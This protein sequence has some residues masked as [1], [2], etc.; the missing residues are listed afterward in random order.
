[1]VAAIDLLRIWEAGLAADGMRRTVLL[2]AAARPPGE[3]LLDVPV[4]ERD[5]DLFALRREL[6]GAAMPVRLRCPTCAEELE[7]DFDTHAVEAAPVSREPITV[8]EGE[9]TVVF[10]LPT[11]ADL[12]AAAPSRTAGEAKRSEERR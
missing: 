11:S 5:A 12:I 7:F 3:E 4:G 10:R 2:H 6:F 1:M 8:D 9:W